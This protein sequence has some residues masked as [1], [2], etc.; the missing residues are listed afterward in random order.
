MSSFSFRHNALSVILGLA[1]STSALATTDISFWHSM[2]GELGKKLTRW[3]PAL[4][5]RTLI[6]VSS[7]PI[8]AITSRVW[9]PALQ[10]YA[11]GKPR[12]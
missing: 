4:M 1:F 7:L 10:R 5:K 9:P 11:R 3:Q 6:I 2:E 8:K 12:P